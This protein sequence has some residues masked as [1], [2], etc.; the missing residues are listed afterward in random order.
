[1]QSIGNLKPHLSWKE[2]L[3]VMKSDIEALDFDIALLGCGT[4]GLPLVDFIRNKL[5]KSAIYIGGSLQILFGIKGKRWDSHDEISD[6][7]NENWIRPSI[8]ETPKNYKV[9]EGGCY[10]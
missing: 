5:N 7:Y 1:M 3:S 4:Y 6:F 8:E 10:W 2:S 9:L